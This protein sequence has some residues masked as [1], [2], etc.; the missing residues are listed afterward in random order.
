MNDD[1]IFIH[2]FLSRNRWSEC[3]DIQRVCHLNV[4]LEDR[5]SQKFY[6]LINPTIRLLFQL[7]LIP[8]MTKKYIENNLRTFKIKISQK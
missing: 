7:E 8:T 4:L 3:E 1:E 5:E 6:R 2:L